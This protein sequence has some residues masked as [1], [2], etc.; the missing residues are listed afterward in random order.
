MPRSS[1]LDMF[2]VPHAEQRMQQRGIKPAIAELIIT[3]A[4]R[5]VHVGDNRT[6][7]TVTRHRAKSLLS[8]GRIEPS[9]VDKICNKAVVVANND[10]SPRVL[11]VMHLDSGK[12]GGHYRKN[13]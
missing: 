9:Q 6:S 7:F 3:H 4:D 11:T 5:E 8:E 12:K 10:Y 2:I 1:I 13:Y